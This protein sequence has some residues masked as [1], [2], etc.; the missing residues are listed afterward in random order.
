LRHLHLDGRLLALHARAAAVGALVNDDAAGAAAVVA[1]PR[2]GEEALGEPDLARAPAGGAGPRS[3]AGLR[4]GALAGVAS[5]RARDLDARG[6]PERRLLEGDLEMVAEIG[7]A[8]PRARTATTPEHLAEDVAEDVVDGGAGG[9]A[10]A[11]ALEGVLAVRVAEAVVAGALLRVGQDRVGLGRLLEALLGVLVP[12]VLVR[13]ELVRELAVGALQLLLAGL[14]ADPQ[15]FVV[16][17][18]FQCISL[19][20][21]ATGPAIANVTQGRRVAS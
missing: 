8:R 5:P 16:V 9:P 21:S 19:S 10:E 1:S 2:D 3:G 15:D 20:Y 7:P 18:F 6:G 14:P 17:A 11:E 13:V 12:R 4:A